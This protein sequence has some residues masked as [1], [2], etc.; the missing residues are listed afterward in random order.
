M[1][2]E[3]KRKDSFTRDSSPKISIRSQHLG[4]NAAFVKEA[5]I[6]KFRKVKILVDEVNF[7]IGFKFHNDK[8]QSSLT[9]FSDNKTN[10][11]RAITAVQLKKTY[12]FI[13]QISKFD[14]PADRQFEVKRD[15][16]DKKFWIATLCPAFEYKFSSDS[17]LKD[18]YGI[19]RYKRSDGE[20]VYIGK[21]KILSRFNSTDRK[22]WDFDIVEYSVINKSED[23]SKWESYWLDKFIEQNDRMPFYNKIKGRKNK[24]E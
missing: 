10:N 6:L 8:D 1:F 19:Y 14:N 4:F 9:L 17:E 12:K 2:K 23:R 7:K 5:E 13:E 11:T 24:N 18:I 3:F 22:N 21:G 20:I 15:T 16:G